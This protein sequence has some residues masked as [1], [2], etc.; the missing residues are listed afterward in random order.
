MEVLQDISE[1]M[2]KHM[3]AGKLKVNLMDKLA[4]QILNGLDPECWA[5]EQI[6]G[7][8]YH[9]DSVQTI[10]KEKVLTD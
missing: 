6:I 10:L 4:I 2:I 3:V 7:E 9:L 5:A 8:E 1:I